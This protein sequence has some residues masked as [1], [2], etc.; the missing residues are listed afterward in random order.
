MKT[1]KVQDIPQA[2]K[3]E[4]KLM[5]LQNQKQKVS[6]SILACRERTV[7]NLEREIEKVDQALIEFYSSYSTPAGK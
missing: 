1:V 5:M 6:C 3:L 7:A 4:N 2:M